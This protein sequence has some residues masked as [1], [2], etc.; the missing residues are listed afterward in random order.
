MHLSQF[1]TLERQLSDFVAQF[2]DL[3]GRAERRYWCKQYLAGL[4]L[5]GERKSV[6]PMAGRV[7]GGDA[8]AMQQFVNQSPW[9]HDALQL[10][11]ARLMLR[12]RAGQR[13]RLVLDDT[14]LPKQGTSSVGVARQYCGALGKVAN[15]QSVVTWHYADA[16]TRFP[17]LGRL[18]LPQV[19]TTEAERM[20]RGGIPAECQVFR[21]KWKIAL[22][23]LDEL[24]P[25]VEAEA[26]VCDAGY[27]EVK[28]LLR[29]L[30]RRGQVFVAQIPE[31]HSFWPADVAVTTAANP[32]GRPR[33][34]PQVAD[35]QAQPLRAKQWREQFE[36]E[37][38]QWPKVRL[39]LQPPQTVEV[40]A[41]RVRETNTQ[42]W[43]R[44]GAERW[45]L[46]ERLSDG[47]IKYYV[48]NAGRRAS[49]RQMGEWA[50]ERWKIEQGY[51]QL[52]EELGLDHFE[53]RSWRGLHHHLTLCFM[54]YCFLQT[55]KKGKK[56]SMD[57]TAG[58]ALV[59]SG[60]GTDAMPGVSQ[61]SSRTKSRDV[62]LN[63]NYLT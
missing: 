43:R 6:E 31:S 14:T 50:H 20:G 48:S 46:I 12:R 56:K 39:P 15:C 47:T 60:A 16:Q 37:G 11:L 35:A 28:E 54:A 53:G 26:V 36:R 21:Q 61:L 18:Y 29:E 27:G 59:K 19:W 40:V 3:L 17:L 32:M 58:K 23:L 7:A 22:E 30:D 8:Q 5:D 57:A 42:A 24:A 55:A 44:P 62:R 33:R 41:L 45:L 1:R 4:L 10:S 38:R 9:A 34:F 25:E 13:A 49:V 63:L 52:K 2:S 51:Q